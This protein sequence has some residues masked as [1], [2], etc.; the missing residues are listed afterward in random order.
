MSLLV[1]AALG[2]WASVRNEPA[3]RHKFPYSIWGQVLAFALLVDYA[4]NLY[5]PYL[6]FTEPF[7]AEGTVLQI[8]DPRLRDVKDTAQDLLHMA[9]LELVP[10]VH[11]GS[12]RCSLHRTM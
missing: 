8:D 12:W 2:T 1:Q 4:S 10:F 7:R 5:L 3:E 6:N 11:M 9:E